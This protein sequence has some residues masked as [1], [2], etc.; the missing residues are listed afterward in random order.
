MP[1]LHVTQWRPLA[2]QVIGKI[3][4]FRL[5]TA[6]LAVNPCAQ[7]GAKYLTQKLINLY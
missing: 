6:L 1:P 5:L 3:K 4:V 2:S 7:C